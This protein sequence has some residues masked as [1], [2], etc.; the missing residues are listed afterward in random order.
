MKFEKTPKGTLVRWLCLMI[1]IVNLYGMWK[2]AKIW[3]NMHEE[4]GD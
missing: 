2:L 1:P 3:S 4:R